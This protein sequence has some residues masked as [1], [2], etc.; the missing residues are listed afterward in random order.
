[1]TQTLHTDEAGASSLI[2]LLIKGG[3]APQ[4]V[5]CGLCVVHCGSSKLNALLQGGEKWD[6]PQ[7]EQ[8]YRVLKLNFLPTALPLSLLQCCS[9]V[10]DTEALI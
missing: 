5:C 10:E 7:K 9:V 6:P 1:M 8:S 3:V 2:F 4:P